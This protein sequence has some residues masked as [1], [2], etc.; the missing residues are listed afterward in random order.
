VKNRIFWGLLAGIIGGLAGALILWGSWLLPS[1]G[2]LLTRADIV[3]GAS[4]VL[5]LGAV[6][7]IL[8]ALVM[9]ERRLRLWSTILSGL[10]L[11]LSYCC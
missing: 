3:N 8:Y 9:G 2:L 4:A 5:I 7:G 1:L 10:A 11:W 6:G